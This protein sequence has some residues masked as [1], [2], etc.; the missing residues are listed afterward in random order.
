MCAA[1][2]TRPMSAQRISVR[3]RAQTLATTGAERTWAPEDSAAGHGRIYWPALF[4]ANAQMSA[5]GG[6]GLKDARK[7]KCAAIRSCRGNRAS[8]AAWCLTQRDG[9]SR[10]SALGD[11]AAGIRLERDRSR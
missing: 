8:G 10:A 2:D 3:Q 1:E 6:Y 5:D 7:R 11:I 9:H 4:V